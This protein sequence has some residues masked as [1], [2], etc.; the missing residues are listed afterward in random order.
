ME[1]KD[2]QPDRQGPTGAPNAA[3]SMVSGR[4]ILSSWSGGKNVRRG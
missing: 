3:E 1:H 2:G 4:T